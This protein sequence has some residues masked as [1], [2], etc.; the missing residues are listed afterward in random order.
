MMDS[1]QEIR[2]GHI[3][4]AEGQ[5]LIAKFDGEYPALYEREFLHTLG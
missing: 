2:N 5:A 1:A 4:T 3:D